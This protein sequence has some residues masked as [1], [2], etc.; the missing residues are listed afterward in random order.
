MFKE[1]NDSVSL[2]LRF[3][4]GTFASIGAWRGFIEPS[5]IMQAM[6]RKRV[7]KKLRYRDTEYRNI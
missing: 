5:T 1:E 2:Y 6:E 4:K 3:L 7:R